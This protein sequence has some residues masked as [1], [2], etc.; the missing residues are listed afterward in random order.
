MFCINLMGA[1]AYFSSLE[2]AKKIATYYKI[3]TIEKYKMSCKEGEPSIG[4]KFLKRFWLIEGCW[5][6]TT[7]AILV[8]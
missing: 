1:C 7:N 8:V 3:D 2:T 4:E 5:V 6:D